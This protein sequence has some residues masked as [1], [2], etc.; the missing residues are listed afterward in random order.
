MILPGSSV[1]PWS[2]SSKQSLP[3]RGLIKIK[4][5]KVTDDPSTTVWEP[6]PEFRESRHTATSWTVQ[7]KS[8]NVW[9]RSWLLHPPPWPLTPD[10][11]APA[12]RCLQPR[13]FHSLDT[14]KCLISVVLLEGTAPDEVLYFCS[15]C[16]TVAALNVC[17]APGERR[18]AFTW[19]SISKCPTS[20]F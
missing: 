11:W 7:G 3:N 8:F 4:K 16:K 14:V 13:P 9:Y 20:A 18:N 15:L 10:P 17:K 19:G 6:Q 2:G 5:S 12:Q 1:W